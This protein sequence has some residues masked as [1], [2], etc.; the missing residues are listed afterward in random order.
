MQKIRLF[1]ST[2]ILALLALAAG[3]CAQ[4]T[5]PGIPEGNGTISVY[6][7]DAP[8]NDEVTSIE[9]TLSEVK[10]HRVPDEDEQSTADNQSQ[11]GESNW[12]TLNTGGEASFDLLEIEGVEHFLG[13]SEIK[14][15]KYTQVRLLIDKV[16]VSLGEGDLKDAKLPSGE[17][18]LVHPFNVVEG[19]NIALL[20]DFDADKMVNVTGAG[21]ITVKPVVKLITRKEKPVGQEGEQKTTETITPEDIKWMLVSYGE[22]DNPII[23]LENTE[24]TA[25]FDSASRK[26]TGSAGCNNYF[27]EYEL[28]QNELTIKTSIGSTRMAC[29]EPVMGQETEYLEILQNIESYE[30]NG[31]QLRTMSGNKV[32]LFSQK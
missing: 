25:L 21:N 19:E 22:S 20:I 28:I 30:I 1:L 3:A 31:N 18:K 15:A 7:T 12:I 27:G 32:L 5:P 23:V 13:E 24:I 4:T 9:V 16:Q 29:P 26:V 14:A 17:L 10:I 8:A 2:I 11:D 6:V